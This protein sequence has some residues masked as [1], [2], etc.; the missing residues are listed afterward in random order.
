MSEINVKVRSGTQTLYD[1][2]VLVE[3]DDTVRVLKQ[4]LCEKDNSLHETLI[5]IVYCGSVMENGDTIHSYNVFDGATVHAFKTKKYEAK[6][7]VKNLSE[8]EM[9]NLGVAFRHLA[10]NLSYKSAL[11]KQSKN[12]VINSIIRT[13]PGLSQDPVAITLLHRSELLGKFAD[14]E[15]VKRIAASHP[16]LACGALEMA[17]SVHSALNTSAE[18]IIAL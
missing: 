11:T 10:M 14:R 9:T 12:D 2:K 13:V 4:K 1:T 16:A 15:S 7:A 3:L 6:P 18:V 8:Y 17:S 5:E